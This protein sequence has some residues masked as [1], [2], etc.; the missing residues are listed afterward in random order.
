MRYNFEKIFNR[1]EIK[2]NINFNIFLKKNILITGSK[3]S[4][5]KKIYKKLS[6]YS[7]K[8]QRID[9]EKDITKK[10]NLNNLKKKKFDFIFH[11]AADKRADYGEQYPFKVTTSNIIGTNNI[12]NLKANKIILASTC[13]AADPLTSY[14]A[15]KLICERIVLNAGGNVARFVNVFDSNLS[16]TRIWK[17]IKKKNIPVTSCSRLFMTLDE[18]VNLILYTAALPKGRYSYKN[19]KLSK[20]IN[21]AKKIYPYKKIQLV[22]LRFGDRPVEKLIGKYESI[23]PLNKKIVQI[24]DCWGI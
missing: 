1:K 12:I 8:I 22:N 24:K 20:M 21:V 13:K 10:K 2:I 18:A 6:K 19:L 7:K 9:I 16:V 17:L 15:S 3:G 14:G 4:I 11:L 23:V 5:G